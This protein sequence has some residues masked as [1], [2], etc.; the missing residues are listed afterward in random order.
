MAKVGQAKTQLV[1]YFLDLIWLNFAFY[2]IKIGLKM[3]QIW[4]K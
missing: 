3:A 2:A 4:R 1:Y